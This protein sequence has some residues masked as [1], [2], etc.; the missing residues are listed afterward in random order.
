MCQDV[1]DAL[2]I[3]KQDVE[4]Q[5]VD[6]CTFRGYVQE[7][8]KLLVR[9]AGSLDGWGDESVMLHALLI[10]EIGVGAD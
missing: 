3:C 2:T 1:I 8:V 9:N 7:S 4:S 6:T 10:A 5:H